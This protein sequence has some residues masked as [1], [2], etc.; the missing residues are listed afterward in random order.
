[1]IKNIAYSVVKNKCPKC[2]KGQV[3]KTDNA[4]N[5]R[6][7]DK[8]DIR[9]S[10]CNERYEKEPGAFY[11]AMYVSYAIMVAWFVTTWAIDTLFIHAKIWQY[12]TFVITTMIL[13]TPITF[14]TAR[15]IWLNFFISYDPEAGKCKS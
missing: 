13:L 9:C 10:C 1:M 5:L 12:L 3:F 8:M 6:M 2:H 7:F 11:G 14:R 15:L 4:Y